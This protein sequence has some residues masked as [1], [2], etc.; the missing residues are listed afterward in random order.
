MQKSRYCCPSASQRNEPFPLTMNRGVPPTDRNARTG[1]S[2]PPTRL[3]NASA[4]SRSDSGARGTPPGSDPMSDPQRV[5]H[6]LRRGQDTREDRRLPLRVLARLARTELHH[7]VEEVERVVRLEGQHELLIVE[8]E[9]I[10]GVNLHVRVLV[11]HAEVIPHD[12]LPVLERDRVPLPLLH[13]RV[14]EEVAGPER[15]VPRRE[16]VLP[17]M[18]VAAEIL[19]ALARS[20]VRVRRFEVVPQLRRRHPAGHLAEGLEVRI[21]RPDHEVRVGPDSLEGVTPESDLVLEVMDEGGELCLL[22]LLH[23]RRKELPIGSDLVERV[24]EELARFSL[25]PR[26]KGPLVLRL[27]GHARLARRHRAKSFAW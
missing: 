12:R 22:F 1:L 8:A 5:E 19:G 27:L 3:S 21:D 7:E 14:H 2:T 24:L 10:R 13:E 23:V 9:G 6:L 15:V 17:V 16:A 26:T 25:L 4:K 20:Q 11:P 18:G